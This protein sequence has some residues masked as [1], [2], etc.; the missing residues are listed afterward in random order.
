LAVAAPTSA[1]TFPFTERFSTDTSN[2]RDSAS[3][4]LAHVASGGSDGG[5]FVSTDFA[6]ENL[7]AG[8]ALFRAQDEFGSSS[9]AFQGD[10]LAAGVGV[11]RA[12]VRHDAPVPIDFFVRLATP[13]NFP[14]V[15]IEL[16][17]SVQ[18]GVAW[19]LLEFDTRF[20]NPLLTPE[21]PPGMEAT[22]YNAALS[23]V[24]HVQIGVSL[25]TALMTDPTAYTFDLDQVSIGV[26]EP[27]SVPLMFGA[28][29]GL[30]VPPARRPKQ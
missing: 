18:P 9:G 24:G 7:V 2:W 30:V 4:P 11:L 17:T 28:L 29:L 5:G 15:A 16:P 21:A 22:F 10:W 19:T 23:N 8:P 6:F 20:S 12:Y 1:L 14:G 26:P 25:P 13:G 27:S 3:L